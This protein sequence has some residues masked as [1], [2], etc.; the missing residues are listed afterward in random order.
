MFTIGGSG[1]PPVV[2]PRVGGELDPSAIAWFARAS[3]RATPS[4]FR[5]RVAFTVA[6]RASACDTL[7]V[8]L[9]GGVGTLSAGDSLDSRLG[10][11]DASVIVRLKVHTLR[12]TRITINTTVINTGLTS[13]PK[14]LRHERVDGGGCDFTTLRV[15]RTLICDDTTRGRRGFAFDVR[16][17][18]S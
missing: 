18:A 16:A 7:G 4:V 2:F 10:G 12:L 15:K 1:S 17:V 3:G 6:R 13:T 8:E 5:P 14:L 11:I 9:G